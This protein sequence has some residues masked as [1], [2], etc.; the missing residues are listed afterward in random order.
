MQLSLID[1]SREELGYECQQIKH[2]TKFVRI[3]VYAF[4]PA[5]QALHSKWS[6]R[7]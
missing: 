5:N 4:M 2:F 7:A 1:E 6:R 3:S